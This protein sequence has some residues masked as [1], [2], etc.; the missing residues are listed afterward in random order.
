MPKTRGCPYH[1]DTASFSGPS[2]ETGNYVCIVIFAV[3]LSLLSVCLFVCL[4]I[5]IFII[6]LFVLVGW[7][8]YIT[9]KGAR[10]L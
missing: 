9:G 10:S 5:Y 4:F 6:H 8:I 1:C 3:V 2:R 7:V